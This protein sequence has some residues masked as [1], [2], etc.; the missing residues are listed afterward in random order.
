MAY[1]GTVV[2]WIE[3]RGFGFVRCPETDDDYFCHISAF[4]AIGQGAPM[5]GD[6][7]SFELEQRAGKERCIILDEAGD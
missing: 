4:T 7:V 5:V 3:D 6:E 1:S 2:R